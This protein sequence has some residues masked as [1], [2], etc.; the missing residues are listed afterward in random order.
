ML[1]GQCL[2]GVFLEQYP[3][4]HLSQNNPTKHAITGVQYEDLPGGYLSLY[5]YRPITLNFG[6][7]PFKY[8][9]NRRCDQFCWRAVTNLPPHSSF[10]QHWG[11]RI[12]KQ[13][14]GDVFTAIGLRNLKTT[15]CIVAFHFRLAI[16]KFNHNQGNYLLIH[17]QNL[18]I[19]N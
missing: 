15:A 1:G 14:I 4:V 19:E 13:Y 10:I 9:Y 11:W 3:G 7:D 17:Q 12:Y 18:S 2:S 8:W 6:W 16:T 5:Y